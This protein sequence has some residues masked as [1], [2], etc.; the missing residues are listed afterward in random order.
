MHPSSFT[1]YILLF[2]CSVG[3]ALAVESANRPNEVDL[4]RVPATQPGRVVLFQPNVRIDFGRRQVEV[5]GEIVMREGLLELFACSP[6]TREYESI[7]RLNT[8]PVV[9]FQALGLLGIE[10]GHPL[11]LDFET[12]RTIP[13]AGDP[14]QIEVRYEA[15]EVRRTIP[16]ETWMRH[17]RTKAPLKPQPW[18]FA[19]SLPLDNG[20]IA[21]DEEG[22]IIAVVDFESALIALPRLHTSANEE[23]WLE[24]NTPAI[25]TVGTVCTL[26]FRP[27]P[28]LLHLD[29]LGRLFIGSTPVTFAVAARKLREF[30]EA[31][32]GL[33]LYVE[34]DPDAP[35]SQR[36]PLRALLDE[37]KIEVRPAPAEARMGRPSVP[38]PVTDSPATAPQ[39]GAPD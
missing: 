20:N 34:T 39:A 18:V 3:V 16:I 33:P 17:S 25:P 2:T 23:L 6:G 1:P 19:G 35:Q 27:A 24:P 37:L 15:D 36:E 21:A 22:T 31:N 12:L 30:H 26:L 9:I 7:V 11:R 8:R 4:P 29:R 13:A 32:P 38:L 14:I 28:L 5:D 10:P